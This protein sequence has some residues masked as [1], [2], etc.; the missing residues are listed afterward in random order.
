MEI[1][2]KFLEKLLKKMFWLLWETLRMYVYK[3][4]PKKMMY[5]VKIVRT[6]IRNPAFVYLQID[7]KKIDVSCENC[8]DFREK[9]CASIFTNWCQNF[10]NLNLIEILIGIFLFMRTNHES[11][12]RV[13]QNDGKNYTDIRPRGERLS[14]SWGTNS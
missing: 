1:V 10:R 13:L 2:V 11:R 8:S 12:L 4:M 14:A 6:S 7:A 5:P 9:P 3:L